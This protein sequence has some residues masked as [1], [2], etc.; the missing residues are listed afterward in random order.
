MLCL[1][2]EQHCLIKVKK[3]FECELEVQELLELTKHEQWVFKNSSSIIF[4]LIKS[5]FL[6]WIV[7]VF[8][9][10]QINKKN[11]ART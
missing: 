3:K 1:K 6:T 5:C 9:Y 2:H 4:F 7:M 10:L 11:P 8:S